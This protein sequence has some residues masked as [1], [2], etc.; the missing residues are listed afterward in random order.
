MKV[1]ALT[2]SLIIFWAQEYT[3]AFLLKVAFNWGPISPQIIAKAT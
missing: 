3:F 1:F 2:E